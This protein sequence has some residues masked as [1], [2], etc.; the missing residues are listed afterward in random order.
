MKINQGIANEISR[1]FLFVLLFVVL[2]G[3]F[4]SF[5][6]WMLLVGEWIGL[7]II[8][9][10]FI[11]IYLMAVGFYS[12]ASVSLSDQDISVRVFLKTK[13][14]SWDEIVQA[15]VLWRTKKYSHENVLV[16]LPKTGT[17][18]DPQ[19]KMYIFRNQFHLIQ[20]PCTPDTIAYILSHY[21]PL[22]FDYSDGK[23]IKQR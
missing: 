11:W 12:Q 14:Y 3:G 21:G 19:D 18:G 13:H 7:L 6:L 4:L 15:G 16:L 5:G 8:L 10:A 17:P 9:Y 22:D 20:L 2:G 1:W 23:G